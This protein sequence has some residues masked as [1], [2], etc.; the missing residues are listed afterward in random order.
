[1]NLSTI[2]LSTLVLTLVA[3]SIA[4]AGQHSAAVAL[5][6]VPDPSP[7]VGPGPQQRFEEQ[8]DGLG[9]EDGRG[10]VS[11]N[12][13]RISTFAEAVAN[14]SGSFEFNTTCR[15][16]I[17]W[18]DVVFS[19]ALNESISVSLNLSLSGSY[20]FGNDG[21]P[22]VD[23]SGSGFSGTHNWSRIN[24]GQGMLSGYDGQGPHDFTTGS[25]SIPT[26]TPVTITLVLHT[27]ASANG[28]NNYA[29]LS[30]SLT[31]GSSAESGQVFNVPAGITVDSVQ[32]G[33]SGNTLIPDTSLYLNAAPSPVNEGNNFDLVMWN[34]IAGKPS[35]LF[36]T[37]VNGSPLF[38]N[39][40][41]FGFVDADGRRV[42]ELPALVGLAG[43][44]LTFAMLT[45]N[46]DDK[47]EFT[48]DATVSIQ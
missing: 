43:T 7:A 36:L 21:N 1:M 8:W 26:N 28:R 23:V 40:G 39:L 13:G 46:S 34:A 10:W 45:K 27:I 29:I 16:I 41:L 2:S 32:A 9:N 3:P 48:N 12:T 33:I 19:S 30:Q 18:D 6:P 47:V 11:T 22:T 17:S 24:G 25:F 44:D 37:A 42:L 5:H 38:S 31:L 4:E 15:G 14:S 35:L 20:G